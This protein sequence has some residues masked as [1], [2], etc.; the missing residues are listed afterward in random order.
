MND[1]HKVVFMDHLQCVLNRD[2]VYKFLRW[3]ETTN[4]FQQKL[5]TWYCFIVSILKKHGIVSILNEKLDELQTEFLFF[6]S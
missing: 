4:W 6:H 3:V 2:L 1:E 5:K